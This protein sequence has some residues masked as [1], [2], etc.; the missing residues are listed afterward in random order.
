MPQITIVRFFRIARNLNQPKQ[1]FLPVKPTEN[2][3]VAALS[4]SYINPII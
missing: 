2:G 4:Q 3:R 1:K